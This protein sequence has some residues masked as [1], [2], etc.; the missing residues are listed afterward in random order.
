MG[1]EKPDNGQTTICI[2]HLK[3]HPLILRTDRGACA[4][5]F[6]SPADGLAFLGASL[7]GAQLNTAEEILVLNP[8][9]FP[10]SLRL[11]HLAT[12]ELIKEFKRDP[13]SFPTEQHLIPVRMPSSSQKKPVSPPDTKQ[14][15][16]G[17]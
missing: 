4:V 12:M 13:Q 3:G 10:P 16:F 11:L 9:A 17:F 1:I 15:E 5:A 6:A 14:N 2:A 8:Q 7:P